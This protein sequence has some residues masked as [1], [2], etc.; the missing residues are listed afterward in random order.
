MNVKV[1]IVDDNPINLKLACNVLKA[2]GFEIITAVDAE[3]TLHNL[4]KITP[5]IILMDIE[6]PGMDGLTLTKL[7]KENNKTK[8]IPVVALTSYAMKGDQEKAFKSGCVGYITKPI[9]TRIFP[10]QVAGFIG[11][12][13]YD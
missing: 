9:D 5:D 12:S 2:A 7:L 4:E 1:L 8:H 13:R 6:L 11:S 3:G 10:S